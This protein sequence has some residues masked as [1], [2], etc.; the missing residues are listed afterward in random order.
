VVDVVNANGG[1]DGSC[2]PN[3]KLQQLHIEK[4]L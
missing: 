4:P 1:I 3:L 2:T